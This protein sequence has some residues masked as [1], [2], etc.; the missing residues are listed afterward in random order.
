MMKNI[1]GSLRNVCATNWALV[2]V[3]PSMSW[4]SIL[5]NTPT[6]TEVS[7]TLEGLLASPWNRLFTYHALEFLR[8]YQPVYPGYPLIRGDRRKVLQCLIVFLGHQNRRLV[9][10]LCHFLLANLLDRIHHQIR[11]YGVQN[12]YKVL[13]IRKWVTREIGEI[14]NYLLP[15]G[16]LLRTQPYSLGVEFVPIG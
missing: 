10:L 14:S 9:F 8:V 5:I 6:V 2:L 7:F 1:R 12:V 3:I 16:S 4:S 11:N 13:F 15:F